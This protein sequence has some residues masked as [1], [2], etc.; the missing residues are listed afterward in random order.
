MPCGRRPRR[1]PAPFAP[2]QLPRALLAGARATLD[3]V[4]SVEQFGIVSAEDRGVVARARLVERLN[5]SPNLGGH[6]EQV[7]SGLAAPRVAICVRGSLGRQDRAV[8]ARL[9]F[10]VANTKSQDAIEHVP[11]LIVGVMDVQRR[12][13][14]PLRRTRIYPFHNDEIAVRATKLLASERREEGFVPHSR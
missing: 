14:V 2:H 8:R 11:S 6:H 5:E 10:L 4:A 1:R 9:K 13:P 12:D 3:R 7:A